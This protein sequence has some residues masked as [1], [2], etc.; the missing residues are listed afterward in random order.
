[1]SRNGL[2]FIGLLLVVVAFLFNYRAGVKSELNNRV[3]TLKNI[4]RDGILLN[5]LRNR[6]DN[7]KNNQRIVRYLKSFSPAPKVRSR[8]NKITFSFKLLN[9][10]KFDALSR[11]VLQSTI[12]IS[13]FEVNRVDDYTLNFVLEIDK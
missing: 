2:I 12:K 11:K 1:M 13:R 7:K 3:A 4:E 10:A 5:D 6:W 9:R 8:G